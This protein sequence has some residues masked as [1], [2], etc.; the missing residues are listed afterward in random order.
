MMRT[1][2]VAALMGA[3]ALPGLAAAEDFPASA[4]DMEVRADDGT[5]LG[6]VGSVERNARGEIV[7]VAVEG[8][9]PEGAP[10]ASSDLV[11]SNEGYRLRIRYTPEEAQRRSYSSPETRTR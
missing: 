10:A 5:V 7:S 9:E 11:A 4:R 3:F 6:R 1:L 2:V 8:L